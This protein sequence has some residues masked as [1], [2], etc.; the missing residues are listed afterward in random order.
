MSSVI[1]LNDQKSLVDYLSRR[2]TS[3][4][5]VHILTK[6]QAKRINFADRFSI[7]CLFLSPQAPFSSF[8][9]SFACWSGEQWASMPHP[10]RGSD[11]W[12]SVQK[13]FMVISEKRDR[14]R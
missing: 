14:E 7:P 10:R 13:Y 11:T 9:Q 12:T 6:M 1:N 4:H 8:L 5:N 3:Q 2:G